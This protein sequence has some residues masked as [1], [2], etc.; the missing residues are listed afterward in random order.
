MRI[1]VKVKTR[2]K[3]SKLILLED[4]SYIASLKSSPTKN[5]ANKELIDL[6]AENFNVPKSLVKIKVGH[7]TPLKVLEI[8]DQ[9]GL[10]L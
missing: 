3:E 9:K 4:N 5:M 2:K 8:S 1:K 6:V 7:Y 10:G